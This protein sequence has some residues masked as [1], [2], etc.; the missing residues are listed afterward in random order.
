M[1]FKTRNIEKYYN[2]IEKIP[3]ITKSFAKKY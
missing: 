1:V 3:K 2:K